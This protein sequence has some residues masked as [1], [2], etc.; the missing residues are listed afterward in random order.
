MLI[1]LEQVTDILRKRIVEQAY[2][3]GERLLID[4]L[5]DEL[6]VSHTPIREALGR[7]QGEGLV[8]YRRHQGYHVTPLSD[9]ELHEM[10]DCRMMIERFAVQRIDHI[11]DELV[12]RL[13]AIH[14]RYCAMMAQK[15][16]FEQ[17]AADR[18]FHETIVSAAG[19]ALLLRL[20]R[21]MNSHMRTMRL[22]NFGDGLLWNFGET[23][24][25]HEQILAAFQRRDKSQAAQA[26]AEHL[27]GVRNRVQRLAPLHPPEQVDEESPGARD[28]RIR[29]PQTEPSAT[30]T[31]EPDEPQG[32]GGLRDDEC[33]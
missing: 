27:R 28:M 1:I 30:S 2:K 13:E 19:N 20:F 7:L 15:Q 3:P 23:R 6:N 17:N 33:G 16:Y 10:L 25:E 14:S 4:K 32:Q 9:R 18:E 24:A 5:A 21:S 12:H 8:S 22:F 11:T 26:I 31:H 29:R